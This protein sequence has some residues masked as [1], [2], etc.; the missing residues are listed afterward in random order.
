LQVQ[1]YRLDGHCDTDQTAQIASFVQEGERI[2]PIDLSAH[3]FWKKD[4]QNRIIWKK[5]FV[6]YSV[7]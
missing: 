5:G 1:G 3:V 2:I 4:E 7:L 6:F